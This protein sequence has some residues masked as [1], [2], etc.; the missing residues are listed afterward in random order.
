MGQ[1][2]EALGLEAADVVL[3]MTKMA[4]SAV[5]PA[6]HPAPTIAFG[7][8]ANS[9]RWFKGDEWMFHRPATTVVGTFRPDII[10]APGY[11]TDISRQNAPDSVQVTI[12]E[13][14][15]LQSFPADFPWQG[16]KGK[17]FLQAGNAVPPGL[18][19]H[20]LAAAAGI[21]AKEVAA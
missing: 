18:A 7:H 9:A 21:D 5:R 3:R 10:A 12:H 11:R 1:L 6:G 4:N 19:L 17:Q 20:A 13:A 15:V 2:A 14:G 8:D 16:A